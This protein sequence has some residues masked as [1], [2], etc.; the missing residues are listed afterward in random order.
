MVVVV[1]GT[2]MFMTIPR[3]HLPTATDDLDALARWLVI[4]HQ[5]L[6]IEA[7]RRQTAQTL[8]ID[9]DGQRLWVT[10]PGM[11]EEDRLAAEDEAYSPGDDVRIHRLDLMGDEFVTTGVF[12]LRFFPDGHCLMVRV[13]AENIAGRRLVVSME[14]FLPAAR[15][16]GEDDDWPR[17]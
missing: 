13:H 7:V 4:R 8:H 5:Q 15:V 2:V 16:L 10:T 14:P 12:D 11:S 6:R 9:L 3:L 1:I 17:T